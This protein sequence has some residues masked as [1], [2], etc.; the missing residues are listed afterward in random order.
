MKPYAKCMKKLCGICDGS[1][2]EKAAGH[3]LCQVT[4]ANLEHNKIV[5]LYCEA[6]SSDEEG[7]VR[8]TEKIKT[9]ISTVIK[10]TDTNGV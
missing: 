8:T 10:R 6:Y 4:A 2:G 7:Y 1:E 5:P 9:V 3:H